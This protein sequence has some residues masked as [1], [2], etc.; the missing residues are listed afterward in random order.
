MQNMRQVEIRTYRGWHMEVL[1]DGGDGWAV[2]VYDPYGPDHEL[3]RSR[4]P[5][6]LAVLLEEAETRVDRRLSIAPDPDYP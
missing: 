6:G 5:H 2:K 1:D 3:L 4:T